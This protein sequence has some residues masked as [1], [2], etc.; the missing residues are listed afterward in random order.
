MLASDGAFYGTSDSVFRIDR[1][2]SFTTVHSI[3]GT[4]P[5][6]L[7]LGNDC[8][9]Y[10]TAKSGGPAGGGVVYRLFEAGHLC[11]RVHFDPLPDRTFGDP[12][13]TLRATSSSGLPV[14]FRASG[15][16]SVSGDQVSLTGAGLCTLTA[17]QVGD[18]SYEPAPEVSQSFDVLFEFTGF[19][20]P[21]DGPPALN[22]VNA[23]R[24]VPVAFELAGQP[25]PDV[26]EGA[27][28]RRVDCD[29]LAPEGGFEPAASPGAAEP[30]S[31]ASRGRYTV[32]WKTQ[33]SWAGSCRELALELV[34]GSVHQA[35]FRF[36]DRPHS[37]ARA[38][39]Q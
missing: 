22:R 29:T 16:C 13:F 15:S 2:G 5:G 11:Q 24:V 17:S 21:V 36:G 33:K 7:V 32:P 18:A 34:D 8:A 3:E 31:A 27:L 6:P 39:A 38:R 25:G 20:P 1:T 19:L 12:P 30:R 23:G 9:V 4:E 26:L 35:Y 14:S 10:G 28:V 37:H